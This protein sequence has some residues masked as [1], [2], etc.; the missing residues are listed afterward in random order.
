M[1]PITE[2]MTNP[3]NILVQLFNTEMQMAS[4]LKEN[5]NI[6]RKHFLGEEHLPSYF[7]S[8]TFETVF[9]C[10]TLLDVSVNWPIQYI[11]IELF[12]FGCYKQL[13]MEGLLCYANR[14]LK[15]SSEGQ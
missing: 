9:T 12:H 6:V 10:V 14:T 2:N 8:L 15:L 7:V 4:L 11:N 1:K 5:K 13:K 3:A